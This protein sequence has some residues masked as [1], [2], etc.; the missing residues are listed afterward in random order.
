MS[1][2]LGTLG[3]TEFFTGPMSA[4]ITRKVKMIKIVADAIFTTL[5]MQFPGT[6][7][8]GNGVVNPNTLTFT[9]NSSYW[10]EDVASF[11]LLSG[12]IQV[13]YAHNA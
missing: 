7:T 5:T 3:P 8:V 9:S 4:V 12:S 2:Q 13:I 1:N 10:I 6:P 11:R